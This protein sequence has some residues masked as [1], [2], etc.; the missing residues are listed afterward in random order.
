MRRVLW[1]VVGCLVAAEAG[2]LHAQGT[3]RPASPAGAASAQV[4]SDWIEVTYGRPIL[5]G[6]TNIFGSG[7]DYGRKIYDGG[8][9]WRAGANQTTI[10]RSAVPLEIGGRRV[11]AGDHALLIDLKGPRDWTLVVSAQPYQRSYDPK[12][13]T[14][15]WG[16]FNYTPA[17]DVVR[18]AMRVEDSPFSMEQ[19]AWAFTDM[20]ASGGTLRIWWEKTSASVPFKIL[21]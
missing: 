16:A 20:S 15:L 2:V 6:R 10:L 14:D 13:T 8:P 11:P 3:Q 4:G 1:M 9:I 17:R 7:A 5:R 19:L 21:R 18:V 12:N